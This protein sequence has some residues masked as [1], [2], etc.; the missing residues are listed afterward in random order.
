VLVLPMILL[1]NLPIYWYSTGNP[2]YLW[3]TIAGF[4]VYAAFSLVA[5]IGL[6]RKRAFARFRRLWYTQGRE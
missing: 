1:I 3:L 5:Y 2:L 4:A 6:A